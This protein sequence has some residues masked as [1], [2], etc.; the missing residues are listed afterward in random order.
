MGHL[1]RLKVNGD[2]SLAENTQQGKANKDS[3]LDGIHIYKGPLK[4]DHLWLSI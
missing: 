1:G 4:K 3:W 2:G